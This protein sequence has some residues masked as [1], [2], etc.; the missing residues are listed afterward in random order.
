MSGELTQFEQQSALI[1]KK[2]PYAIMGGTVLA[3]IIGAL[4]NAFAPS[5][6]VADLKEQA[7]GET[8]KEK[9]SESTTTPDAASVVDDL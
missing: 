5:A 3:L 4:I 8:D 6:A 9:E 7:A 1:P 2:M